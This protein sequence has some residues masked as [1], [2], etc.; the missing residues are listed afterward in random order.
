MNPVRQT[1]IKS[2][3][4]SCRVLVYLKVSCGDENM[5]KLLFT[6]EQIEELSNNKYVKSITEESIQFTNE[7]K[8]IFY[9][10]AKS[11]IAPSII[12]SSLGINPK[13]LGRA[14]IISLSRR[15]KKQGE[16]PEGFER[17]ENSSKGK[18]RKLSFESKDEELEYYKELAER[19]SQE[20]EFLK[21]LKALEGRKQSS[22]FRDK[23]SKS[24]MEC[25]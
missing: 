23:S 20:N 11:G 7:F 3:V 19:L 8:E 1:V 9:R 12:L 10:K 25:Q 22:A 5:S 17:K 4:I 6:K 21:K 2:T 16:R 18:K 13:I 15:I 24:S 14:R